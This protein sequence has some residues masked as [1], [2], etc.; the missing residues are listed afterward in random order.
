MLHL[1]PVVHHFVLAHS[2]YKISTCNEQHED[3]IFRK[4]TLLLG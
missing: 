1:K 4:K 3:A 2:S